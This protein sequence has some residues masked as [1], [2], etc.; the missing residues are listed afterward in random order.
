[1]AD[2]LKRVSENLLSQMSGV[3]SQGQS[4][5]QA[6]S[7]LETA[8]SHIDSTLQKRH[9]ELSETLQRLSGKADQIDEVMRGYSQRVEGTLAETTEQLT[10]GAA[11]HSQTAAAEL[12][13]LR[14]QTDAQAARTLE[15]MRARMSGVSQ[16][17]TQHLS[18]MA[19]R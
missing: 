13:R 5:A 17:V 12:E 4:L 11:A 6:A 19:S 9:G 16:E 14:A 10:Q 8:N 15:E 18:G 3:S 7:A 2:L 1:Q